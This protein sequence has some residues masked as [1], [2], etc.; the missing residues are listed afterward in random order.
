[1]K[2]KKV[3]FRSILIV[4]NPWKENKKKILQIRKIPN[5]IQL[6]PITQPY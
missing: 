1:M 2:N 3:K 6:F 4:P 5:Q